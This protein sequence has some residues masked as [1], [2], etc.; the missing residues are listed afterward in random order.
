MDCSRLISPYT[1]DLSPVIISCTWE[2]VDQMSAL[3]AKSDRNICGDPI[4]TVISWAHNLDIVR[5]VDNVH[6][7]KKM[8]RLCCSSKHGLKWSNTQIIGCIDSHMGFPFIS[9]TSRY[10]ASK[11]S[12]SNIMSGH[13]GFKPQLWK[14]DPLV[15]GSHYCIRAQMIDSIYTHCQQHND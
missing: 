5:K 9:L 7:F 12:V 15:G 13:Q 1:D 11:Q 2:F 14:W 10:H 8:L 4:L 6:Q 3:A